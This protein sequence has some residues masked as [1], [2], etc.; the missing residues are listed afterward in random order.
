MNSNSENR[1]RGVALIVVN[2]Y[3]EIIVLK[4][5]RN[6]PHLGKHAGMYSIPMETSDPYE[7]DIA[8]LS[9]L[10]TEELDGMRISILTC[11]FVGAFQVVEGVWVNLY[12]ART[13]TMWLPSILGDGTEVAD[14]QW[15]DPETA[16]RLWLRR[17]AF[18]MISAYTEGRIPAVTC[19]F[20][21]PP[22]E[23]V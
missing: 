15:C 14:A 10:I 18:E 21:R 13:K 19:S 16:L 23:L 9:R 17:G 20:C 1:L 8:T 11:A 6:K 22:D 12:S 5:L 2:P 3:D 4:E 7:P